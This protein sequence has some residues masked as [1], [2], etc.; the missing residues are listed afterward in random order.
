MKQL[1]YGGTIYTMDKEGETVEALLIE[2]GTIVAAGK[3]AELRPLA[4]EE[5]HLQQA[6]MYP[7]FVDSHLHLLFYGQKLVRLDLSAAT[8]SEEMLELVAA[9]A[10][11]LPQG[12]WLFGQGWN[13]TSFSDNVIPTCRQLDEICRQPVMLT[14]SCHHVALAN[15]AA[16]AASGITAHTVQ[17]QGGIIGRN[18][19]GELN[20]LLYDTTINMMMAAVKQEG[21]HYIEELSQQLELAVEAMLEKGLTGGHSEDLFYFGS[22]IN[23][24][25]AFMRVIGEKEHFRVHLLRHHMVFEQL[26]SA[27]AFAKPPFVEFGAMKLFVDGALGAATAALSEPYCD[28]PDNRGMLIHTRDKLEELVCLARQHNEAVAAHAIGDAAAEQL[29]DVLERF[30]PPPGKLDRLI[31]GCVLRDDLIDRI[32]RLP[33]VVDI[34]P[35]FVPAAFPWIVDR[36]GSSR[37]AS[38]YRWKSL[39]SAGIRCAIG[40]DAPIC[41]IDPLSTIYAAVERKKAGEAHAGYMPE[42]KLSRYEAIS[43]YTRGSAQAI[44][45]EHER[46]MIKAGY[47]ADFTIFDRD[48]FAGTS[49]QMLEAQVVKTVVA[50]KV[51]YERKLQEAT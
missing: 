33:I 47:V 34:Q 12:K 24:L 42:Q 5:M 17:P 22:F 19:A 41:D 16:L 46:G 10:K 40:T 45:K 4:D 44:G 35:A 2:N 31:H 1:W 27:N 9:A 14:R 49:E 38:A 7:G 23:P 29:L 36:L 18:S 43:M 37:L 26:L 51:V 30:P 3:L 13:E 50:G 25:T 8:S 20:G 6:V 39:A 32:A 11:A 15:S 21:E 48:L 28:Q